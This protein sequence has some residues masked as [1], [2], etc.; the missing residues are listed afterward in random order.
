[1]S[2]QSLR[3]HNAPSQS[4]Q[5]IGRE[6]E[7]EEFTSLLKD[8]N[9]RLLALVGPGGI[10]KSRLS[11]EVASQVVN[12]FADN[13]YFIELAPLSLAENIIT[14]IATVVR[15]HISG[16][17][18]P[19]EQLLNYLGDQEMLLVMDNFEHLLDGVDIVADILSG[20]ENVK[21][22]VTSREALNLQEEWV[23]PVSGMRFPHESNIQDI[24]PYSALKLFMERAHRIRGDFDDLGCAIRIC[25]LVGG[26]PLAIELASAWLKVM[27]CEKIVQEIQRNLDFLV[28]KSRNT[29][30]RHRSIRAVFDQ[31]WQLLSDDEQRVLSRL[32]VFHGGFELEAA[33][34]VAGAS[35]FIL[36]ELVE[37]S[38]LR[39][40]PSG[41]YELH[42]L[43]RQYAQQQLEVT[44]GIDTIQDAH[45]MYYLHFMAQR[46]I[47]I[48]NEEIEA[49]D[50][51]DSDF[52]NVRTAWIRAVQTKR[53][54][55]LNPPIECLDW[56][57]NHRGHWQEARELF[58]YARQEL[59]PLSDNARHPVWSRIVA[60]DEG[61]RGFVSFEE[62]LAQ[63]EQCLEVATQVGNHLEVAYC[64]NTLGFIYR[65][66]DDRQEALQHFS[67]ALAIYTDL[68]DT[69]YIAHLTFRV[70]FSY[71]TLR[72]GDKFGEYMRHADQLMGG[73]DKEFNEWFNWLDLD[74]PRNTNT[75]VTSDHSVD[76]NDTP[77]SE[78]D[79]SK[80]LFFE[81]KFDASREVAK[82]VFDNL[83]IM[84]NR[85]KRN[86]TEVRA[87]LMFGLNA[88]IQAHYADAKQFLERLQS[89]DLI[90]YTV[91]TDSRAEFG[92][93]L[94]SYG[95]GDYQS[96]RQYLHNQMKFAFDAHQSRVLMAC[97]PLAAIFKAHEDK[98]IQAV[99]LMAFAYHHPSSTTGWLDNWQLLQQVRA[100]L[101]V[102]LGSDGLA[103]AWERGKNS[104]LDETV[105]QLIQWLGDKSSETTSELDTVE[106]AN[107]ALIEPLSDREIEV[108]LLIA[109]GESNQDIAS[110]LFVGLSTVKKHINHIYS[111]LGIKSR[112]QAIARA[113]ELGLI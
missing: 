41:R 88:S 66:A 18:T 104:D 4:M 78:I 99:E 48:K 75:H 76:L 52:E 105:T 81:G 107:N 24:A 17:G 21:I 43:L 42:E 23:R 15:F 56:F 72:Q 65:S 89:K 84:K 6:S 64:H 13:V 90:G 16:D 60:R 28:T 40:T 77:H 93:A 82:Q 31:S 101:E 58:R 110:Q 11:I 108:L 61:Y 8:G 74:N 71:G 96:A 14:T 51:I 102:E 10:G 19:R 67:H 38:L 12:D 85:M 35:L 79:R 34:Q 97:I 3:V 106:S 113:R 29:D 45:C 49:V 37:K 30:E 54:D 27:P 63:I 94:A 112:T 100:D 95:L 1:M 91:L 33:E 46:E 5:F 103:S 69:H 109:S 73:K 36:A 98:P 25:Q 50:E 53:Y 111:K 2:V 9:C 26:M 55:D 22:L 62:S 39:I 86:T 57:S 32:S 92:L 80:Q 7:I 59:A 20:C 87:L 70:G 47:D 68:Y 44:G 83:H